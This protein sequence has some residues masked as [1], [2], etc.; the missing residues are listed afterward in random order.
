MVDRSQWGRW[1]EPRT[2][3]ESCRVGRAFNGFVAAGS[4]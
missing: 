2:S 4:H 3:D 1:G